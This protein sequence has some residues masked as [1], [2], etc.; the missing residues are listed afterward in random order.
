MILNYTK[1]ETGVSQVKKFKIVGVTFNN[2]QKMLEKL[3]AKQ[4]KN[5]QISVSL[6]FTTFEGS[7]AIKVFA[8]NMDIGNIAK[9]DVPKLYDN[10]NSILGVEKFRVSLHEDYAAT[11]DGEIKEDKNGNPIVTGR[12]F[13]AVLN[14]VV[15]NKSANIKQTQPE[16]VQ[17][18]VKETKKKRWQ[19]WK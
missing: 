4:E 2:R 18:E 16:P 6:D 15:A 13:S 1:H 7:P 19:F 11:K 17:P 3:Y 12:T 10:Q 5:K 8:D 9:N 14:V